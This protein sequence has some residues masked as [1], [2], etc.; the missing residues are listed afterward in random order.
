MFV[1][2]LVYSLNWNLLEYFSHILHPVHSKTY[3]CVL[4]H[5]WTSCLVV[6]SQSRPFKDGLGLV[7]V[8]VLNWT[9]PP[10]LREHCPGADQSVKPPLVPILI[11]NMKITLS[12]ASIKTLLSARYTD[13]CILGVGW[14]NL[15][16]N[17]TRRRQV[18]WQTK[19]PTG[20]CVTV[21]WKATQDRNIVVWTDG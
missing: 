21:R 8:L 7:Q 17:D 19:P 15:I 9:P 11:Y 2:K 13:Y 12:F 6:P 14:I 1:F 18:N 3:T 4:H 16:C 5:S 10:Q 20:R